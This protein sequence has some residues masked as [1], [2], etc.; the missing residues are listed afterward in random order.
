MPQLAEICPFDAT[1]RA[2]RCEPCCAANTVAPCVAAY[3]GGRA[4]LPA[5]NIIS[6]RRVEAIESRRAA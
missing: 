1:V 2:S 5:S 4:A 6:I 3:L